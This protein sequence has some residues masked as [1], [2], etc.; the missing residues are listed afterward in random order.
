MRQLV[1]EDESTESDTEF[2]IVKGLSLVKD[3]RESEPRFR[4]P[5]GETTTKGLDIP[6]IPLKGNGK[7]LSTK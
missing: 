5:E 3:D 1:S 6:V 4:F 2:P 7:D